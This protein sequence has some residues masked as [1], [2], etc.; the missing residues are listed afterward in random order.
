MILFDVIDKKLGWNIFII[1]FWRDILM[2][3][4]YYFIGYIDFLKRRVLLEE[5]IKCEEKFVKVKVVSFIKIICLWFLSCKMY[6]EIWLK[7]LLR[8][9][10]FF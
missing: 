4:F 6:Y 3:D 1:F 7:L 2:T 5:V 8:I 9:C 10:I